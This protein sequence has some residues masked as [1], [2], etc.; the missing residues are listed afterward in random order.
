MIRAL[1]TIA[2]A[3]LASAALA[4]RVMGPVARAPAFAPT[5]AAIP[6]E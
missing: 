5:T 6:G 2:F 3:L 4:L 1:L